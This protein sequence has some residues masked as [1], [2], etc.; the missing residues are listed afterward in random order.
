MLDASY[1]VGARNYWKSHFF[2]TL[3]DGI[4]ET[5]TERFAA[6]PSP[7]GQLVIEH[8]HGA[9]SRVPPTDTAHALRSSGFNLLVL[10][11]WASADADVAGTAWARETYQALAPFRGP[12]RYLNYMDR[13]DE[14]DE[15]LASVYGPNLQRLQSVKA[16]YDPDNVF[17][18]NVNVPPRATSAA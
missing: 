10:S 7:M 15:T 6:C 8:F 3:S 5:L 9:V 18:L 14:G 2:E 17:H 16:A 4:I 12:R 1:P 13:D 11:Q